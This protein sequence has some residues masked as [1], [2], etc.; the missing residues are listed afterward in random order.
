MKKRIVFLKYLKAIILIT[1]ELLGLGYATS[2]RTLVGMDMKNGNVGYKQRAL[3]IQKDGEYLLKNRILKL[4]TYTI[5]VHND[6]NY[7]ACFFNHYWVFS[8][9]YLGNRVAWECF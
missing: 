2:I 9:P 8:Y 7:L 6:K 5:I 1:M 3:M 4:I